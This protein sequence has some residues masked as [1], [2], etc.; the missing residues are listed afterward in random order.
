MTVG[1]AAVATSLLLSDYFD[2]EVSADEL[3][4]SMGAMNLLAVPLGAMP[5]CHGSGGV[6][7][8]YAFGARTAGSN[9]IL[10]GLYALAA[11]LAVGVVAAFPLAMLGVVL[12]VIAVELGRAGLETNDLPLTVGIG[13][14]GVLTNVG[15]AFVAGIVAQRVRLWFAT[16]ADRRS[17]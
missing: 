8:K 10:G 12:A 11:V 7:G 13:V 15:V 1:N 3:A 9:L 4:T 6:A 5:M 17:R 16:D 14:L 2:A